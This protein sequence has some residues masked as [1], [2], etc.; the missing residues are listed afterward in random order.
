MLSEKIGD[1]PCLNIIKHE[2]QPKYEAVI[3]NSFI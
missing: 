2:S 3:H 1:K